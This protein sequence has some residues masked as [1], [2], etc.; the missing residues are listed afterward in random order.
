MKGEPMEHKQPYCFKC[1]MFYKDKGKRFPTAHCAF[2][3]YEK[4][5]G[6]LRGEKPEGNAAEFEKGLHNMFDFIWD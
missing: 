4:C 6:R 1:R 5:R 2:E 3:I